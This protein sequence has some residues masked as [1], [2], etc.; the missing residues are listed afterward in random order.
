MYQKID[1]N[2]LKEIS[3]QILK[4]ISLKDNF[5]EIKTLAAFTLT[6]KDKKTLCAVVV[7]NAN[8]LEVL[9]EKEAITD[10]LMP[11]SPNFV[12]FREGPAIVQALKELSNKPDLLLIDGIGALIPNKVGTASYVGVLTNRPCLA[13]SKSLILGNL[14]EDKIMFKGEVKG[15]ALRTKEF[16]NPVYL[17]IGHSV[18][19]QSAQELMKKWINPEFKMPYP[20]HL[21]H[22]LLLKMKKGSEELVGQE[23]IAVGQ[24]V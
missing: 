1:V 9:E 7:L 24:Q 14:E 20:L 16:A 2:E 18:S 11:Y 10:E 22:K 6:F 23:K 15:I 8:T 5:S 17:T 12:A 3:K 21:A 13:V 19:L 4:G